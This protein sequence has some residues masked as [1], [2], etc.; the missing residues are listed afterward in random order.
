MY[1]MVLL[2]EAKTSAL[3]GVMS[4]KELLSLVANS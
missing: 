1:L 3:V 4:V 2:A